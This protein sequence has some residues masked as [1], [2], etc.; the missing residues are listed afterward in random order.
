MLPTVAIHMAR[1][2]RGTGG[3][4]AGAAHKT[5][6]VRNPTKKKRSMGEI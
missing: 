3:G 5:R 1:N 4:P 2:S 6:L